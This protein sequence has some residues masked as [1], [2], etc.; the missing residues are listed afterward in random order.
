M[1]AHLVVGRERIM[2]DYGGRT[3]VLSYLQG[4]RKSLPES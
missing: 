3:D 4:R 1:I 2:A